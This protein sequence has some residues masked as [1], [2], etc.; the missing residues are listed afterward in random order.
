M[1]LKAK[2][3]VVHPPESFEYKFVCPLPNGL[4]ARPATLFQTVVTRFNSMVSLENLSNNKIANARSVLS[5]VGTDIKQGDECI[6]K[7]QGEDSERAYTELVRFIESDLPLCD[8]QLPDVST[9]EGNVYLP[10]VLE[11]AGVK[12]LTGTSIVSGFGRGKVVHVKSLQLPSNIS[13]AK[14]D[15]AQGEIFVIENAIKTLNSDISN[16]LNSAKI[17]KMEKEILTAHLAIATDE[18]LIENI[19]KVI[20]EEKVCS[21]I[22]ILKSFEE[23]SSMLKAAQSELIRERVADLQDVCSDLIKIIYGSESTDNIV[24]TEPSVCIADNLTP[25]QFIALDKKYLKALVLINGSN[26]SHTAILARSY[27]IPT[28]VGIQEVAISLDV[29]QEIIVDANYGLLV[30]DINQQVERFYA[31]EEKINNANSQ[32]VSAYVDVDA[33]TIDGKKIQVKANIVMAD[34]IEVAIKNGANGVGLFRTEMFFMD[35]EKAPTE[36][37]HFEEYKKAAQLASGKPITIRTFDIGGDKEVPCLSLP[38]E[39]NPFL[40]YRGVRIYPEYKDLFKAQLRAILRASAFGLIKIMIPMVSS[41]DEVVYVQSVID[42][43]KA[44]LDSESI[45]YDKDIKLGVNIEVPSAAFIIPQLSSMID[46]VSLG[47]NDLTQY[48]MAVDRGNQQVSSLYQSRHPGFLS[49]IKNIV[50]QAHENNLF[51]GMCGEMAGQLENLPLLIGTGIDE[52]SV[53]IPSVLEIK[54]SASQYSFKECSALLDKAIKAMNNQGV[55]AI[56]TNYNSN[57]SDKPIVDIKLVDLDTDCINKQEVINYASQV[58]YLDGRTTNR[59]EL[60]KDF[61]KREAVYSTGLGFGIAVP[62][63]KTSYINCNSISVLRLRQPVEWE[64]IDDAPVDVIISMTIKDIEQSGNIH[65]KIF[66]KLARNI[67]HEEF[68]EN[69]R[70]LKTEKEVVRYLYNKL[71]LN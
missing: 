12:I 66:S 56:L 51:V 40:G 47:T 1:I 3:K 71:E 34:E 69:L 59:V 29:N 18:E 7:I 36:Q 64:S 30:C 44:E 54:A 49:L 23:F 5:L 6:L 62:H 57:I 41:V 35:S 26:T 22:A 52:L 38:S 19:Q 48:F 24:L 60:E 61:W 20:H 65:M 70:S 37:E 33:E 68:R 58:L 13:T 17:S 9:K 27:A 11:A 67:M 43:I 14:I 32:R 4:H 50:T 28:L 46:F 39:I 31:S 16:K 10:P 53:S 15:D 25:S 55:D 21:G 8:E 45:D 2:S 42:E 63:C